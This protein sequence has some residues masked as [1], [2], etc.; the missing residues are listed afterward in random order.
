MSGS[1]SAEELIIRTG[2]ILTVCVSMTGHLAGEDALPTPAIV[3]NPEMIITSSRSVKENLDKVVFVR[4]KV[5]F[6][7]RMKNPISV[8]V[9]SDQSGFECRGLKSY[10]GKNVIIAAVPQE[11][12]I[13]K[14]LPTAPSIGGDRSSLSG[15]V[16]Y[17][18]L[19]YC[20]VLI[21]YP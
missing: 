8:L 18:T 5:H 1:G 14:R 6:D 15:E 10:A 4:G 12:V 3:I 16:R 21:F 20:R 9:L 2:I 19:E 11:T 13:P 7:A 17:T